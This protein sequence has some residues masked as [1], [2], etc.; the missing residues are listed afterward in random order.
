MDPS[1]QCPAPSESCDAYSWEYLKVYL[2]VCYISE[3]I[4][5]FEWEAQLELVKQKKEFSGPHP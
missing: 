2:E 5:G 1:A 3:D 4:W